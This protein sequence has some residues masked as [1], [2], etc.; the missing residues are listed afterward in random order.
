VAQEAASGKRFGPY[1]IYGELARGGQGAIYRATDANDAPCALKMLTSRDPQAAARFRQ[2][3]KVLAALSHPNLLRVKDLGEHNQ[4]PF[5][6]MEY[7]DGDD[8][9]AIVTRG[10]PAFEWSARVLGAVAHALHTCHQKGLVHRDLKPANILVETGTQRPVLV[11]F[12]LVKRDPEQMR[13]SSLQGPLS[14]TGEIRGTPKYMAPEQAAPQKFGAVSQRSDVYGL[15]ATLFTL[16]TGA[17]PFEGSSLAL[18]LSKVIG[19]PAPNPRSLNP[20]VPAALASFCRRCM[21]KT[22]DRRPESAEAFATELAHL[23]GQD[24]WLPVFPSQ[25]DALPAP[26]TPLTRGDPTTLGPYSLQGLLGRGGMGAVYLGVHSVLGVSRAIKVL[27]TVQGPLRRQRFER[28]LKHLARVRHPNVISIHDSGHEGKWAWFAMDLSIGDDLEGLLAKRGQLPWQRACQIALGVAQ[29]VGALHAAGIVHRDLKPANVML[30][31]DGRP[32]VLD[33]GLAV[34]PELDER[35]TKTGAIVGTPYYLAPEQLSSTPATPSLDVYAIGLLLFELLTGHRA[36]DADSIHQVLA[37]VINDVV[38]AP[39]SKT[40]SVPKAVDQVCARALHKDPA[41]RYADGNEL[42][43][44]LAP[45]LDS[46]H[47][48]ERSWGR[49]AVGAALLVAIAAGAFAY[50]Q[51]PPETAPTAT[52]GTPD[53]SANSGNTAPPTDTPPEQKQV[54]PTVTPS[55]GPSAPNVAWGYRDG[56]VVTLRVEWREQCFPGLKYPVTIYEGKGRLVLRF[57]SSGGPLFLVRARWVFDEI[58][59]YSVDAPE[60]NRMSV[61]VDLLRL[62]EDTDAF[63]CVLDAVTEAINV[64]K[65]PAALRKKIF[66]HPFFVKTEKTDRMKQPLTLLVNAFY[67][68]DTLPGL[69]QLLFR[70]REPPGGFSWDS[71]RSGEYQTRR[72]V[73]DEAA[74]PVLI[75]VLPRGVTETELRIRVITGSLSAPSKRLKSFDFKQRRTAP[76]GTS[77]VS[78]VHCELDP[79]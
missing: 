2:E 46:D 31:S 35:L 72:E 14:R 34:A 68:D 67:G 62:A 65:T 41:R 49:L 69:I 38:A 28:E 77:S 17:A 27:E 10:I 39:S 37:S 79:Q 48:Q 60:L 26:K 5:L 42:A 64:R 23:T 61:P 75:K 66:K 12:G 33:L 52:Q 4:I 11:D 3:G 43:Q 20:N 63:E 53:A 71:P 58:A 6:A 30:R 44:A 24:A 36:V 51:S 19:D 21:D 29:G 73:L 1:T 22:Q 76:N 50:T 40:S 74:L 55:E 57:R 8:L 56:D 18:V 78:E 16:L 59:S 9:D 25:A 13:L 7:V 70:V 45:L 47:V 15:G 54:I 32:V